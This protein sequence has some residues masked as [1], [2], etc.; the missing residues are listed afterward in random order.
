MPTRDYSLGDVIGS[1]L[2][3]AAIGFICGVML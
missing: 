3:A 2:L 1:L